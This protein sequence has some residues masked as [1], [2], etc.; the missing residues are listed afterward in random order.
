MTQETEAAVEAVARAIYE[1]WA[2]GDWTN[3]QKPAWVEMGNS[4]MQPLA[5]DFARTA[6][7]AHEATLRPAIEAAALDRAAKCAETYQ[8]H[9]TGP[10]IDAGTARNIARDIRALR[11]AK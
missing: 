6:I 7:A 1:H 9:L 8:T 11:P 4:K 10:G 5:R 3:N 2:F